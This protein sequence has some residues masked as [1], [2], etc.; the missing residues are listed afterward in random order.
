MHQASHQP[1]SHGTIRTIHQ[2]SSEQPQRYQNDPGASHQTRSPGV[3]RVIHGAIRVIT[4][5]RVN[6]EPHTKP[7]ITEPTKAAALH[8]AAIECNQR[9]KPKPW[10]HL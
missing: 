9:D 1:R 4:A 3:T 6:A 7:T 5:F 8:R 10:P 2:V